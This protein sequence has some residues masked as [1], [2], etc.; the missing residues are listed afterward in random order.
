MEYTTETL[1]RTG[2]ITRKSK[3]KDP[4]EA[5]EFGA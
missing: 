5:T 3:A 4:T 1:S 2:Q